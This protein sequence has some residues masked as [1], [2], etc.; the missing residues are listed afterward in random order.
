MDTRKGK[1]GTVRLWLIGIVAMLALAFAG[2][3]AG[4]ALAPT[5]AYAAADENSIINVSIMANGQG[6]INDPDHPATDLRDL[7]AHL[8][9]VNDNVYS[10]VINPNGSFGHD[11]DQ[12]QM[13]KSLK[14]DYQ[15]GV[16]IVEGVQK[17]NIISKTV[18]TEG[19]ATAASVSAT[20][21]YAFN[22]ATQTLYLHKSVESLSIF[23]QTYLCCII[24]SEK[25]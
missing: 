22:K 16:V 8:N 18:S 24:I 2:F 13:A 1:T 25:Y 19:S 11:S 14:V 9:K 23:I 5:S 20:T 17:P 6:T 7:F 3:I 4:S 15:D 21:P 12:S 10:A